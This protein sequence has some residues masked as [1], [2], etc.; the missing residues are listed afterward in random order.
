[1]II[2]MLPELGEKWMN[3]ETLSKEIQNERKYQTEVTELR[4]TRTELKNTLPGF[5]S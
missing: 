5:N 3:C 2:K 1:M 4:D